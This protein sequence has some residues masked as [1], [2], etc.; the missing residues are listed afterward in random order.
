MRG[1]GKE[2]YM[3]RHTKILVQAHRGFRGIAPENTLLAARKGLEAGADL[4]E[5]DVAASRDGELVILHD[6]TLVRTTDACERF[7]D[8]APWSVYDFDLAELRSLDAGSWY[9]AVDPFGQ[10][11]EGRVGPADL[12]AFAGTRLPTLRAALEL[13]RDTGWEAN[14]EIK[15][16]TGRACDAWIVERTVDMIREYG[17]VDRCCVS[18]FNHEYLKRVRRAEP[19]L[20]TGALVEK[21][22]PAD[23]VALLRR[24]G[25]RSY[26]PDKEILDEP[27]AKAVRAAGFDIYVWTVNDEADMKRLVDWGVTGLITDFPDLALRALGR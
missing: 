11:A 6:D 26:N 18:S 17:L 14:V 21:R 12:A 20:E 27:T 10:I 5:L 1:G 16:A 4:W 19:A 13:I 9:A 22:A 23:V 8:R 2:R 7:P 3:E 25:A 15:D 24:T